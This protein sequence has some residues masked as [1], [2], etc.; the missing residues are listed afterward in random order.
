[1]QNWAHLDMEGMELF[2]RGDEDAA[3]LRRASIVAGQWLYL[4]DLDAALPQLSIFAPIPS[5][6]KV[7]VDPNGQRKSSQ[8]KEAAW[9]RVLGRDA[10]P[11]TLLYP[12]LY[13]TNNISVM[14]KR[15]HSYHIGT[16][17]PDIA[18]APGLQPAQ[19]RQ[20]GLVF[21]ATDFTKDAQHGQRQKQ[22]GSKRGRPAKQSGKFAWPCTSTIS[23]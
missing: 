1:M 17:S 10:L 16:P 4:F 6:Y 9:S 18:T 14:L 23:I 11:S 19:Q 8:V 22:A 21:V 13:A 5:S 7:T 12:A 15:Q 20:L 3:M 2:Q